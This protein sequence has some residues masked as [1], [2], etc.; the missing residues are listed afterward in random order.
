MGFRWDV[1][2]FHFRY[3]F[4]VVLWEKILFHL[5]INT[6]M[7]NP[8][9]RRQSLVNHENNA[10]L[11]TRKVAQ[12]VRVNLSAVNPNVKTVFQHLDL[13]DDTLVCTDTGLS[14]YILNI[15]DDPS[16]PV[17][18]IT[19]NKLKLYL[20]DLCILFAFGKLDLDDIHVIYSTLKNQC[21]NIKSLNIDDILDCFLAV[22]VGLT[23]ENID[24]TSSIKQEL[25]K[26]LKS[27]QMHVADIK[28]TYRVYE[29]LMKHVEDK[30]NRANMKKGV[31]GCF[32]DYLRAEDIQPNYTSNRKQIIKDLTENSFDSFLKF[33][34]MEMAIKKVMQN[35]GELVQ[36]T[37]NSLLSYITFTATSDAKDTNH[38]KVE[39]LLSIH[40]IAKCQL[41]LNKIR[42]K[43][44]EKICSSYI[45]PWEDR[46]ALTILQQSLFGVIYCA[47]HPLLTVNVTGRQ[48]LDIFMLLL[49]YVP[50]LDLF[51][52]NVFQIA[53][54]TK[55]YKFLK[56]KLSSKIKLVIQN[57][58]IKESRRQRREERMRNYHTLKRQRSI[59][60]NELDE[61]HKAQAQTWAL[62]LNQ[63]AGSRNRSKK[64]Y[65]ERGGK[66][67]RFNKM[68]LLI[69]FILKL[70]T[71]V[72]NG[73][74]DSMRILHKNL[75]EI[76]YILSNIIDWEEL[77]D[78][79]F[80]EVLTEYHEIYLHEY[81][82][83]INLHQVELEALRQHTG[84]T[85]S[86]KAAIDVQRRFRGMQV[87]KKMIP[88]QLPLQDKI[89]YLFLYLLNICVL[90][91][92]SHLCD[93]RLPTKKPNLPEKPISKIK[94]EC[95][96]FDWLE[97]N[98]P[99]Y[100]NVTN[101]QQS[102][103][104][105]DNLFG[106][107]S[108]DMEYKSD[109]LKLKPYERE[110][111][112]SY[113]IIFDKEQGTKIDT[114]LNT[115][116]EKYSFDKDVVHFWLCP[117]SA[118]PT[119]PMI[120]AFSKKQLLLNGK[121][122]AE[123]RFHDNGK[124]TITKSFNIYNNQQKVLGHKQL[125]VIVSKET[126]SV[127]WDV[128]EWENLSTNI[129]LYL[130][131]ARKLYTIKN[132]M[133]NVWLSHPHN[134]M[135]VLIK[136]NWL[137]ACDIVSSSKKD[138][139]DKSSNHQHVTDETYPNPQKTVQQMISNY[140]LMGYGLKARID[141]TWV[142]ALHE[143]FDTETPEAI[144]EQ[145][146]RT[147]ETTL[148]CNREKLVNEL[149]EI[150]NNHLQD[151]SSDTLREHVYKLL[152]EEGITP[153]SNLQD[154]LDVI[155]EERCFGV[156][157]PYYSSSMKRVL[158]YLQ[159]SKANVSASQV[160]DLVT[161]LKTLDPNDDNEISTCLSLI[162]DE[163]RHSVYRT[164]GIGLLV[165]VLKEIKPRYEPEMEYYLSL[166][167]KVLCYLKQLKANVSA[168]QVTDLVTV[169]KEIKPKIDIDGEL[170]KYL[171]LIKNE[172]KKPVY[173]TH[174]IGL[175][176]TL[177]KELKPTDEVDMKYYLSLITIVLGRLQ[178]NVTIP[179]VIELVNKVKDIN[180]PKN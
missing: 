45:T 144:V 7:S 125:Q 87:R 55:F 116:R 33:I 167:T 91:P 92:Q 101:I 85:K 96:N 127:T 115:W 110:E 21:S 44:R 162:T 173:K 81:Y 70:I 3:G 65:R 82:H 17:N 6:I 103:N 168:S 86:Q 171:S 12:S 122:R 100:K 77:K 106:K 120:Q 27:S 29:S 175:L 97:G 72:L 118:L 158:C 147:L 98:T 119:V 23:P 150:I 165:S 35:A 31:T 139:D 133:P 117:S 1:Y 9:K 10:K 64:K 20:K 163:L 32:E 128:P 79:V 26:Y 141:D 178:P 164:Q 73:G 14:Q 112:T 58:M 154:Y 105:S 180:H 37:F 104:L 177:L 4:K 170:G 41:K 56:P 67:N 5:S 149:N 137:D 138:I 94:I 129:R 53:K 89:Y 126:A 140:F 34:S 22:V 13:C 66:M 151:L 43:I 42:N 74:K 142:I 57:R 84:G 143:M 159:E 155:A 69:E 179:E 18:T 161:V 15:V 108:F 38:A 145:Y 52:V 157:S 95:K 121:G 102:D 71:N 160:T 76:C 131:L 24:E 46:R 99:Y 8:T 39:R 16:S 50:L 153:S 2:E 111:G 83:K 148:T 174:G 123:F 90:I 68:F 61:Q 51:F 47:N 130:L 78:I 152:Q 63:G 169:L 166:I 19:D 113:V 62:H 146:H 25:A 36:G 80:K 40:N 124:F 49:K 48:A 172:S 132:P 60:F 88:P 54:H 75:K 114:D 134:Q 11:S 176:V 107:I 156:I 59:K 135:H 28:P 30:D 93:T 109:H 136:L